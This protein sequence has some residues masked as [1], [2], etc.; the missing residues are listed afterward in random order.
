MMRAASKPAPPWSSVPS[1]IMTG[2]V[3]L[4]IG[5]ILMG[6]YDKLSY[7]TQKG[8]EAEVHARILAAT[9]TAAVSFGDD[10]AAQEYVNA[11]K[12]NPETEAVAV[13]GS[14]GKRLASFVRDSADPPENVDIHGPTYADNQVSVVVPVEEENAPPGKVYVRALTESA[15]RRTARY[16]VIMLFAIMAGLMLTVVGLAQ[17]ILTR[18]NRELESK[19]A[20]LSEANR[21]LHAE[22]EERARAE[23]ALRQSQKM[24]AIGQLSGGIAHDFNNLLMII[25][26]N[27]QLLQK[28]VAAGQ[29]DIQRYV[30]NATDGL[31]RAAKLTQQILAFSRRQP[32]SPL[33]V[34]FNE[35]LA[36]IDS[37][38]RHSVGPDVAIET[39]LDSR[40]ATICDANQMENVILNLAINA[41]DAMP[42]GGTLRIE[43]SDLLV[44]E[45]SQAYS[46]QEGV[47]PGAYVCLKVI[48]N[49]SG[50]PEEVRKRAFDPFF[51]TKPFGQGTGLG[52][53]MAFG[54]IRQS[55]GH[56]YID[57]E[58][59]RGTSVTIILPRADETVAA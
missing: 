5:G 14:D 53:S 52:L 46:W 27:L 40:W 19:A 25:K 33:R 35:L 28:R 39:R 24:E 11:L 16:G 30:D 47:Q 15:E 9:V 49:G 32:L 13:Y 45:D 31:S 57:S 12:A 29:T 8:R 20:G 42:E 23:E 50:M 38:L 18:A 17:R 56:L 43:T 59:G 6:Y 48:D 26:G 58:V 34:T 37:L 51:T 21:L 41:R 22:M 44:R 1:I 36:N 7:Q 10:K 55:H 2:A 3:L 54:F 4:I